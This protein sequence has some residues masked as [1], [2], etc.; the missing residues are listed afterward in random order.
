MRRKPHHSCARASRRTIRYATAAR[1]R[2]IQWPCRASAGS[3]IWR[4]NTRP[5]RAFAPL[6]SL[7][8][9]TKVSS[10]E[11]LQKLGGADL[12]VAVAPS[13][14][15]MASTLGGLKSRGK[16]LLLAAPFDP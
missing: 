3:G 10:A 15:A 4:C 2:A 14:E 11:G 1:V 16:L 5:K 8:A 12:V 9:R 13:G 6:R 7:V